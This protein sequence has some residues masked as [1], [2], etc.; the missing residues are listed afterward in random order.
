MNLSNG[1][2]TG[3]AKPCLYEA[4]I[5]AIDHSTQTGVADL[6]HGL[7][8]VD[9]GFRYIGQH[10]VWNMEA[11]PDT[12]PGMY[13]SHA[14]CENDI[15][16]LVMENAGETGF[17]FTAVAVLEEDRSAI[18][19]R[20]C[21]PLYPR[22]ISIIARLSYSDLGN[23]GAGFPFIVN[24][25]REIIGSFIDQ[26]GNTRAFGTVGGAEQYLAITKEEEAYRTTKYIP[27]AAHEFMV[28]DDAF[29]F[30]PDVSGRTEP[31]FNG[32]IIGV[33]QNARL[34]LDNIPFIQINSN[35][36]PT[37]S[38]GLGNSHV[39]VNIDNTGLIKVGMLYVDFNAANHDPENLTND[40]IGPAYYPFAV[41]IAEVE[42]S[43]CI[44]DM[45]A[46]GTL[47]LLDLEI[48]ESLSYARGSSDWPALASS[49]NPY[50]G[51]NSFESGWYDN[52]V[53]DIIAVSKNESVE[54]SYIQETN[55]EDEFIHTHFEFSSDS[56]G[57]LSTSFRYEVLNYGVHNPV[58]VNLAYAYTDPISGVP[59][60]SYIIG[61]DEILQGSAKAVIS[62]NAG[63]DFTADLFGTFSVDTTATTIYDTQTGTNVSFVSSE[64]GNN[65]VDQKV[66]FEWN[67]IDICEH[68]IVYTSNYNLSWV[69]D[70]EY[71]PMTVGHRS[72]SGTETSSFTIQTIVFL[73][74]D[75][76]L[77]IFVYLKCRHNN[78][79]K[80]SSIFANSSGYKYPNSPY[81]YYDLCINNRGDETILDTFSMFAPQGDTSAWTATQDDDWNMFIYYLDLHTT[82]NDFEQYDTLA[83]TYWVNRPWG[84]A[85]YTPSSSSGATATKHAFS[86][87]E[88]MDF[89]DVGRE[90]NFSLHP[91]SDKESGWPRPKCV[92]A[93]KYPYYEGVS[94]F[95]SPFHNWIMLANGYVSRDGSG[96]ANCYR[97]SYD[98]DIATYSGTVIVEHGDMDDIVSCTGRDDAVI[99]FE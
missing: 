6:G 41:A 27:H 59:F 70:W 33:S 55:A 1:Q 56:Y 97:F 96:T 95:A 46:L 88:I 43:G 4:V 8:L 13:S 34:L 12:D 14:F 90:N 52:L 7:G 58:T 69:M 38:S 24:N 37:G 60:T 28:E 48:D 77:G 39:F 30:V 25:T 36:L 19:K 80:H 9:I 49:S 61:D 91:F 53:N 17:R 63:N 87:D 21:W 51:Y 64:T 83:H 26:D 68:S 98:I 92:A 66:L 79:L 31:N 54:V 15:V 99:S 85:T 94:S 23:D 57:V 74:V 3:M 18:K 11:Y 10:W 16:L 22:D 93:P 71:T 40:G 84:F 5:T 78:G 29:E 82:F 75:V 47:P 72:I 62:S 2:S 42:A 50:T 32:R 45:M 44:Y 35:E 65:S 81:I 67:S 89:W 86:I 73:H 20:W 76:K